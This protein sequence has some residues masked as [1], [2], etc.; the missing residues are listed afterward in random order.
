M[1]DRNVAI[2]WK[3]DIY[4]NSVPL[5]VKK[6]SDRRKRKLLTILYG[7]KKDKNKKT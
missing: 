6:K 2:K 7:R 4:P 5:P 3:A 1:N